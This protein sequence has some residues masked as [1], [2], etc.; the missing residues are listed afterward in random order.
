MTSNSQDVAAE[1]INKDAL[2]QLTLETQRRL[3][4]RSPAFHFAMSQAGFTYDS[5]TAS[6]RR[7]DVRVYF[8]QG[9]PD[10][11]R[12]LD[13]LKPYQRFTVKTTHTVHVNIDDTLDV[14]PATVIKEVLSAAEQAAVAERRATSS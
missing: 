1:P 9:C 2:Y 3:N 10:I 5:A 12:R 6:F 8:S 11:Q 13:M 4:E 7:D 14:P